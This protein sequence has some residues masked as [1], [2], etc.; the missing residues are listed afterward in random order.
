MTKLNVYFKTIDETTRQILKD[1]RNLRYKRIKCW[2]NSTDDAAKL[3][4]RDAQLIKH[5]NIDNQILCY[6]WDITSCSIIPECD[7]LEHLLWR[8]IQE[9]TDF[10]CIDN[11]SHNNNLLV[12]FQDA[13]H[14]S[15]YPEKFIKIPCFNKLEE[16]LDYAIS[17]GFFTFSLDSVEFEKCAGINPIQGASVYKEK[18]T[19]YYWYMDMFHKTHYEVFD[20]TGKEHIGEA[21][22]NGNIDR[23]KKD[24]KKHISV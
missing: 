23:S 19:G 9:G 16:L 17:T 2:F 24:S 1:L 12:L 15:D 7:G 3:K 8:N 20:G 22:L 21:D 11:K 6:N 5:H 4:I 18:S 10:V 13:E 14:L